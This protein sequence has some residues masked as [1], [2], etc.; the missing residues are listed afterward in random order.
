MIDS[1]E[2]RC[3]VSGVLSNT[4]NPQH[5]KS[6]LIAGLYML[7]GTS[8]VTL[9]NEPVEVCVVDQGVPSQRYEILVAFQ[10]LE[11]S[12]V[13]HPLLEAT[14]TESVNPD[15]CLVLQML[16]VTEDGQYFMILS[17]V[18]NYFKHLLVVHGKSLKKNHLHMAGRRFVMRK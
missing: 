16:S 6:R 10:G 5:A 18:K 12:A 3:H 14:A 2:I 7:T 17:L 15:L 11:S 8:D 9:V 1:P 13:R 4:N